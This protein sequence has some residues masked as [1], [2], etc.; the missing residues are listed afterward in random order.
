MFFRICLSS[1]RADGLRHISGNAR[2]ANGNIPDML[3]ASAQITAIECRLLFFHIWIFRLERRWMFIIRR[4]WNR[5]RIG[6]QMLQ[7]KNVRTSTKSDV[8]P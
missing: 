6:R 5:Q 8:F 2:V 4:L 3:G 7:V 1:F